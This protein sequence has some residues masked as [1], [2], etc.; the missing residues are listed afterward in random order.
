MCRQLIKFWLQASGLID[1]ASFIA[2]VGE[3]PLR[4]LILINCL[5]GSWLTGQKQKE[6]K[7]RE[8]DFELRDK[9]CHLGNYC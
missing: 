7:E 1:F 5:G 8:T 2:T 9:R 4:N 6:G 3:F